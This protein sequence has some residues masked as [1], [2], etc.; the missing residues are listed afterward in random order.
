MVFIELKKKISEI[1]KARK[2]SECFYHDK[3]KCDGIIKR[4][5]SIQRNGRLSII[6]GQVNG[7]NVIYTFT[8]FESDWISLVKKLKPIGKAEASTFFGFCEYHDTVLFLPIEGENQY[9]DSDCHNFLHSYRSFAHSYH[10]KREDVKLYSD[11]TYTKTLPK[12][13]VDANL[14]GAKLGLRDLES[15]KKRLDKQIEEN[16]YSD[17]EYFSIVFPELYP[18][19][20]STII[21]PNFSY[22]GKP[23]NFSDSEIVTY[24][25]LILTVLP[26]TNCT[27]VIFAWFPGDPKIANFI[28]E[29][30]VLS[31]YNFKYALSSI[32]INYAENTFFSPALYNALGIKGQKQL[33]KELELGITTMPSRF[34]L[35]QTNFFSPSL[36]SKR[37]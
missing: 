23:I 37:L 8:E 9:D 26:D 14:H 27:I 12:E 30:E 18:I 21:T 11:S 4:S 35:C 22:S 1:K 16:A 28:D 2:I 6:E 5:H 29:L 10:R 36:S 7:Q 25:P 33:C 32:L 31:D 15:Y 20:C 24:S 3:S 19:A 13:F 34:P 17:L